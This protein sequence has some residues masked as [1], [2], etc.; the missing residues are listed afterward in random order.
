MRI[1]LTQRQGV[2]MANGK[3]TDIYRPYRGKRRL[4]IDKKCRR[5]PGCV[6]AVAPSPPVYAVDGPL[7]GRAVSDEDA[8][9]RDEQ[10]GPLLGKT[11]TA[12]LVQNV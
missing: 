6:T 11:H 12:R 8:K 7:I 9:R 2:A 1:V 5:I 10:F 4:H 3:R